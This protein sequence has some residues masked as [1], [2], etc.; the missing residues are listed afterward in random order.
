MERTLNATLTVEFR[1]PVTLWLD[2][3]SLMPED[4]VSG[5]RRFQGEFIPDIASVF[6]VT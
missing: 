1:A 5:W 4:T 3:A 2:N 6:A